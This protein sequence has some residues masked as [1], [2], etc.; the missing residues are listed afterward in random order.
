MMWSSKGNIAAGT[1]ART[2]VTAPPTRVV[3]DVNSANVETDLGG[4]ATGGGIGVLASVEGVKEGSVGLFAPK[5]FIDAGDAG[6]RSTGNIQI[7]AQVVLNSSNIN[8][9]GATTGAAV[10]APSAPSVSSVT[11]ASNSAAASTAS[12]PKPAEN[13]QESNTAATDNSL[14]TVYTVEVIGYGGGSGDEEND[15]E[16]KSEQN[17]TL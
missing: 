7:G 3:I 2:V 17:S 11:S 10:A 13:K 15:E 14:P 5:G 8:S 4:L 9:G 16:K 1:A 6:I 12:T